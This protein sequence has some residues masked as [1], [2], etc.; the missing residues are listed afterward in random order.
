MDCFQLAVNYLP[1]G[2]KIRLL[3][4]CCTGSTR[5]VLVLSQKS[6]YFFWGGL[7]CR[8]EELYP[9]PSSGGGVDDSSL[10]EPLSAHNATRTG[11][12][13]LVSSNWLF[14]VFFMKKLPIF[15]EGHICAKN[16]F[17]KTPLTLCR[18][19]PILVCYKTSSTTVLDFPTQCS[20]CLLC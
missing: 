16:W 20:I 12:L 14:G 10:C 9:C 3:S 18:E 2:I 4:V 13:N 6:H 1:C 15:S 8:S 5:I 19:C 11:V 17:L 7:S